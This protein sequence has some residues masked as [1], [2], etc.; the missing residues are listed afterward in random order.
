MWSHIQNF[1][2]NSMEDQPQFIFLWLDSFITPPALAVVPF[3]TFVEPRHAT[4]S[5]D[6]LPEAFQYWDQSPMAS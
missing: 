1:I 6:D 5:R 4:D 3:P 2:E